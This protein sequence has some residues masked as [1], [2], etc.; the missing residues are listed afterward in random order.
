MKKGG[1]MGG[2]LDK[3]SSVSSN[4]MKNMPAANTKNM[5]KTGS[6][7]KDNSDATLSMTKSHPLHEGK[8]S[9]NPYSAYKAN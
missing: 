7:Y 4:S 8:K 3:P 9:S 1:K 2:S 5:Y 6:P